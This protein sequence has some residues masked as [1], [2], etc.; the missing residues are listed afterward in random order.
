MNDA[1]YNEYVHV[2]L[3]NSVNVT[4]YEPLEYG[5]ITKGTLR[6]TIYFSAGRQIHF[7][8]GGENPQGNY[9]LLIEHYLCVSYEIG[10]KEEKSAVCWQKEGF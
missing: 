2:N 4:W 5:P 7:R 8:T 1:V 6:G 3:V 10:R 9:R